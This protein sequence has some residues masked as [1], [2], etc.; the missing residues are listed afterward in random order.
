[1]PTHFAGRNRGAQHHDR[2]AVCAGI[3]ARHPQRARSFG[4]A[5]IYETL[6]SAFPSGGCRSCDAGSPAVDEETFS[7]DVASTA[8]DRLRA[9]GLVEPTSSVACRGSAALK[10]RT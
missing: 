4:D 3:A 5:F 6:D 1:M 2:S 10:A 9:N 7:A 8:F